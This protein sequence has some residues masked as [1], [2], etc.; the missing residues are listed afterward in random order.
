MISIRIIRKTVAIIAYLYWIKL[1]LTVF[2]VRTLQSA[3]S[4]SQI[5]Y[6]IHV[7]IWRTILT[8]ENMVSIEV[9]KSIKKRPKLYCSFSMEN[10]VTI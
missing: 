5:L 8:L 3:T 9:A 7:S 6:M 1:D 2:C 4:E 10:I